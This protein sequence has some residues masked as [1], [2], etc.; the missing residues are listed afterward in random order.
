MDARDI[1]IQ[2]TTPA[3]MVPIYSELEPLVSNGHRFLVASNGLWIEARRPWFH[4]TIPLAVQNMVP[5]PYGKVAQNID[6]HYGK[7]PRSLVEQFID[8]AITR[9][10]HECAAWIILNLADET[11]RLVIHGEVV[12]TNS[13]VTYHRP[14]LSDSESAVC[15]LHSHGELPAFFSDEDDIDNRGDFNISIVVGHCQ[16]DDVE[17]SLRLCANGLYIP[18]EGEQVLG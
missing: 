6:L 3:V 13:R 8:Y 7:I 10:P 9:S 16:K 1:A 5:M 12:V 17:M 4:L 14:M 18:L 15:D 11:Y 2:A